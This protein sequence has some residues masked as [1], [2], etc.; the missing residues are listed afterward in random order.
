MYTW[1]HFACFQNLAHFTKCSSFINVLVSESNTIG[2]WI[3]RLPN[4]T[5]KTE[6]PKSVCK[7][8]D[9]CIVVL[10]QGKSSLKNIFKK[11]LISGIYAII[12]YLSRI[13][14]YVLWI[15]GAIVHTRESWGSLQYR[16]PMYRYVQRVYD[17]HDLCCNA[18]EK[19][20]LSYCKR[21]HSPTLVIYLGS[22]SIHYENQKHTTA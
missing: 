21:L 10:V 12:R 2:A 13:V 5:L 14:R 18:T 22:F 4:P 7:C 3:S 8:P 6:S 17:P 15:D 19:P 9:V 16:S 11:L 1:P 20:T